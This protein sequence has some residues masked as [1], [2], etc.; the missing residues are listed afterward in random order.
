MKAARVLGMTVFAL[1]GC[2]AVKDKYQVTP[3][4]VHRVAEPGSPASE[5][6]QP[7]YL[8]SAKHYDAS[9]SSD[10]GVVIDLDSPEIQCMLAPRAPACAARYAANLGSPA[11]MD[12]RLLEQRN[13]FISNSVTLSDNICERHKS[14]IIANANILNVS[15]G[16]LTNIF[17]GAATVVAPAITK[18]ALSAAAGLSNATRS[19]VN[20]EIYVRSLVTTIVRAIDQER[21]DYLSLIIS[22][23]GKS[24]QEYP[25]SK[26]I[27]DTESYHGR[28]SF[29]A[30][31][32][33]V[34]AALDQQKESTQQVKQRIGLVK[35]Q[36]SDAPKLQLSQGQKDAIKQQLTFL[37]MKLSEAPLA[38]AQLD[39]DG[40]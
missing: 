35:N 18:S 38:A 22:S 21:S 5:Q 2:A 37:T 13:S 23:M 12:Q 8:K 11:A 10:D 30:G 33:K 25:V 34:A 19:T 24:I 39:S 36:L 3:L 16:T 6:G 32:T 26:A 9:G 27:I 40:Q 15:L 1:A 29:Y 4:T 14:A 31:V 20:E 7:S 28:C 17:S